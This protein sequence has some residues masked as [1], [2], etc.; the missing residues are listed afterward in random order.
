MLLWSFENCCWAWP[1][2]EAYPAVR[3][4]VLGFCALP[5]FP[6]LPE[7]PLLLVVFKIFIPP[8]LAL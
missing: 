1:T 3:R 5:I 2:D 8:M 7:I 4:V 6:K